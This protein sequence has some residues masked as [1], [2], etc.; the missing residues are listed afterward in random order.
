MIGSGKIDKERDLLLHKAQVWTK[1]RHG[2]TRFVLQVAGGHNGACT[3]GRWFRKGPKSQTG[4]PHWYR[5]K[6]MQ[7]FEQKRDAM[8]ALLNNNLSGR[9]MQGGLCLYRLFLSNGP[10][11]L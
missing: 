5:M 1:A 3:E 8:T 10:N 9:K 4:I 2:G 6:S 7:G 11:P